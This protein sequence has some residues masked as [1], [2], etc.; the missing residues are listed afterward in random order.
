MKNDIIL[1]QRQG[2]T[3]VVKPSCLRS[4][5]LRLL[6]EG[7]WGATKME[8]MARRDANRDVK[9]LVRACAICRQVAN[10]PAAEFKP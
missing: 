2:V 5:V 4:E 9:N 8:H 3:R 6:L 10:A 1:L 7:R